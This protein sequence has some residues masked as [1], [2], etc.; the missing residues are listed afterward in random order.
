[1]AV[2]ESASFGAM[3][4]ESERTA[5]VASSSRVVLQANG[6]RATQLLNADLPVPL[7]SFVG[8][9]QEVAD[10]RRLLGTSRLL[11]LTGPGGIGKTR[12]ALEAAR[13]LSADYTDGVALA[14]LSALVASELVPKRVADALGLRD[15]SSRSVIEMLAPWWTCAGVWTVFH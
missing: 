2:E 13:Q 6:N 14:D 4:S 10:V 15:H 3:L 5:L 12:L 1:M 8:R 7:S 9:E 11:T